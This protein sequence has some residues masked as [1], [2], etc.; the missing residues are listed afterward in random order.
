MDSHQ[1]ADK[2]HPTDGRG[3][4]IP[5]Q[6]PLW[7]VRGH[8]DIDWGRELRSGPLKQP[9]DLA[10]RQEGE[11]HAGVSLRPFRTAAPARAFEPNIGV[12]KRLAQ[13]LLAYHNRLDPVSYTHLTLPTILR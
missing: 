8:G 1:E 4:H 5:S 7:Q 3:V 10:Q 9:F 2:D 13:Q 11:Q 6:R 12:V